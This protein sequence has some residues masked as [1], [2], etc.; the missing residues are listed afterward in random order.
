M[1]V[2]PVPVRLAILRFRLSV[3][4]VGTMVFGLPS[5]VRFSFGRTPA[6]IVRVDGIIITRMHG[7]SSNDYR[8]EKHSGDRDATQLID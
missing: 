6:V 7:T 4:S 1:I 2:A 5:G 3:I 8:T